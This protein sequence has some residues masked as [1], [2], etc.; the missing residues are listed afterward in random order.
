MTVAHGATLA[1]W[2]DYANGSGSVISAD[3]TLTG[4]IA[5][6]GYDSGRINGG[7]SSTDGT[8]GTLA[9][10]VTT[11]D[12]GLLVRENTSPTLTLNITNNTLNSYSIDTF[13]FDFSVRDGGSDGT[14]D[15]A[16][17]VSTPPAGWEWLALR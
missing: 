4:F 16:F 12:G 7:F 3:S 13:H 17:N 5:T 8:F 2:N 9:G 14:S 6:I 15:N 1:F 10:G 11:L